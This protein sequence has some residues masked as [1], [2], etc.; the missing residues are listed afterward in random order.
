MSE[1]V[2]AL[3]YFALFAAPDDVAKTLSKAAGAPFE[4]VERDAHG[5]LYRAHAADV[6]LELQ[7]RDERLEGTA[8]SLVGLSHDRDAGNLDAYLRRLAG[9]IG[10]TQTW[11]HEEYLAA[12]RHRALDPE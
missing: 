2:T 9:A 7:N 6:M 4:C 5:T 1:P 8:Y 12:Q 3:M 10:A 11:S